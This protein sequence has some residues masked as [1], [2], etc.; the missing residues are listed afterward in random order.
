[1]TF[2][3]KLIIASLVLPLTLGATSSFAHGDKDRKG[4][5]GPQQECRM[6]DF[7][8]G[9][10]KELALTDNQKEQL[11]ELRK[12]NHDSMKAEFKKAPKP[13]MDAREA[14]MKALKDLMMADNFNSA[15]ATEL[16]QEMSEKRIERQV[17]MLSQ[18]HKMLSVLT[19]DQKAKFFE[20]QQ[21]RAQDCAD[22]PRKGKRH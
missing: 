17:N 4:P 12:A 18:Q 14:H 16:A 5:R 10:M 3:K 15:K 9:M 21:E 20:L 19:A 7:D 1:M 22:K 13:D 11:K 8:R 2:S 6:G